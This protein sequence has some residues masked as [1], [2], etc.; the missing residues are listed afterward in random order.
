MS[1]ETNASRDAV[2]LDPLPAQP[3]QPITLGDAIHEASAIFHD[4]LLSSELDGRE[5]VFIL[6]NPRRQSG[7][8]N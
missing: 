4:A 5:L 1:C 6:T 3:L 7:N 2:R 8:R